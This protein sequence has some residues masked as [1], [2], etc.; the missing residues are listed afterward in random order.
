MTETREGL[1]AFGEDQGS[2]WVDPDS[3]PMPLIELQ[4]THRS[5]RRALRKRIGRRPLVWFVDDEKANRKWFVENHRSHFALLTFSG[6]EHVVRA[7]HTGTLCD[8]V[9]TDLFF[10]ATPP[11]DAAHADHLLTIYSEIERSTVSGLT[12]V[13]DRWKSEWALDGLDIARDVAEHAMRFHERI[14][15]LLYS[16]KA[17]LLLRC[18]DWL[19]SP[20]LAV[21]NTHWMLEKLD[22]SQSGEIASRAT[23]IQHDRINAVLRYR[24]VAAP[25]WKRQLGRISIGY[26]PYRYSIPPSRER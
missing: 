23:R 26:G 12:Q 14:P 25:W 2:L 22:P 16:R 18:S 24:R 13:W 15:V 9:V 8:A 3:Q 17:P 6:R 20:S 19:D 7:L 1:A 10:P 4:R 5:W 11:R 21:E